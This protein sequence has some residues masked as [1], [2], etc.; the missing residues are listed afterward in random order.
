M[1]TA[2]KKGRLAV[3]AVAVG[4]MLTLAGCASGDPLSP[5]DGSTA[6]GSSG[7]T[8]VIGSQQYYSNEIIAELYAQ[9]L[10]ANGFTV[11]RQYQIGQREVYLPELEKGTIDLMPEYTGNLLQYYDK[12]T[13]AHGVDGVY[14]A[15]A[16]AIPSSLHVLDQAPAQDQDS[17][18]VTKKFSEEHDLH[19]LADLANVGGTITIAG[20]AELA[21]RPYGPT[22]LKSEYGVDA[23][24]T[25]IQDSGGPLTV[26]AL[27][28]GTVQLADIYSADPA[29]KA[30][31]L[32]TLED[33]KGLILPQNV[34][35]L[36][37]AKVTAKAADV[38]DSVS[39]KLTTEQ[40]I[41]LNSLSVDKKESS[42]VI[43]KDW[44]TK[45]GFLNAK[46]K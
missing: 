19:S 10:E 45:N 38:I 4:A 37:T 14:S 9:T 27:T 31:D 34:V 12:D 24:V 23:T 43:A 26:K 15:L 21:T 30:N 42:S 33:P 41:E 35:P 8:I 1:I 29:I 32:V 39:A 3:A 22:G 16:K 11:D 17:Y 18:N 7:G 6:S 13:T 36:A 5:G 46:K 28:D 25:P 2:R 20:N 44:L 40:L